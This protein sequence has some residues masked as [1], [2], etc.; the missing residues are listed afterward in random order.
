M[1]VSMVRFKNMFEKTILFM[2]NFQT[3][4]KAIVGWFPYRGTFLFV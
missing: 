4:G 2:A 1:C 3:V